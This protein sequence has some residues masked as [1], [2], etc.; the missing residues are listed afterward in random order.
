MHLSDLGVTLSDVV[1]N[2]GYGGLF[3]LIFLESAGVPLPGE[4]ALISAAVFAATT[5]GLD[6]SLIIVVAASGA[7]LGDNLGFWIGYRYGFNFLCRYGHYI[8]VSESRLIIGKW[9]FRRYGGRVIFFG[10]FTAFLR[11]YAALLAGALHF[12]RRNFFFWNAS[13]GVFW[14]TFFGLGGYSFGNAITYVAGL[15]SAALLICVLIV[16]GGLWWIL[17]RYEARLLRAANNSI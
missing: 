16:I 8:H 10:R 4:A 2:Y 12:P 17:K 6:I 11:T 7:I 13:G 14:A 15:L 5:Q 3:L 1:M 9:L